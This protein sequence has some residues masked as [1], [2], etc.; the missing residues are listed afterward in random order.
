[1]ISVQYY[2]CYCI[3]LMGALFPGHTVV[4]P[5]QTVWR[6]FDGNPSNGGVK[7]RRYKKLRFSTNISLYL[8][9]DTKHGDS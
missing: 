6:Y 7:C 3:L 8:G 9:N 2:E 4:F 1:M 5:H